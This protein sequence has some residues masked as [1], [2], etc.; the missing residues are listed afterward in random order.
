ML[1]ILRGSA[2]IW[3]SSAD[4]RGLMEDLCYKPQRKINSGDVCQ[5]WQFPWGVAHAQNS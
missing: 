5:Y 3:F 2:R 1:Q 4:E